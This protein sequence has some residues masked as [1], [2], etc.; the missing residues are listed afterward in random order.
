MLWGKVFQIKN[1]NQTV[2]FLPIAKAL[3]LKRNEY[4]GK[5]CIKENINLNFNQISKSFGICEAWKK[6]L[7]QAIE[8]LL[9]PIKKVHTIENWIESLPCV[10][11]L[12]VQ[13]LIKGQFSGFRGSKFATKTVHG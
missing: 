1:L 9:A 2:A 6:L 11:S 3:N 5:V 4:M 8:W 7:L 13:Q 10:Q 12:A